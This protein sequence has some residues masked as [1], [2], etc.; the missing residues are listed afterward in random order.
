MLGM[1][2]HLNGLISI[3]GGIYCLLLVCGLPLLGCQRL[4]SQASDH[5]AE[6][7]HSHASAQVSVWESGLELFVELGR[8]TPLEAL[9]IA[10]LS[11]A[12]ILGFDGLVGTIEVGKVANLVVFEQNP[13]EDISNVRSVRHVIHDG[14][15]LETE[16]E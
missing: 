8:A 14:R 13:L 9:Q 6:D 5:H 3:A 1:G 2:E 7:S 4:E 12:R 10:T 16:P 15:L 11:S